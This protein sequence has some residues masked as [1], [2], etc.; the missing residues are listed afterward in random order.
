M[1][2]ATPRAPLDAQVTDPATEG[3][4]ADGAHRDYHGIPPVKPAPFE[5]TYIPTYFWLGGIAAGAWLAATAE[6]LAGEDDRDVVRAG[7]YLTLASVAGGTGLLIADL[8]RPERFLNMLRVFRARSAMSLGAWGLST[9]GAYSGMAA[10]LQ[11]AEDGLLGERPALA[12][13]SRGQLGRL[14]HLAG[15]PAALF[16]GSYTGVLLSSTSTPSWAA[17]TGVLSPLFAASAVSSGLAAVTAALY[18]ADDPAPRTVRRLARAHAVAAAA[19]TGLH[20]ADRRVAARLPSHAQASKPRRLAELAM[21]AAGMLAPVALAGLEAWA[22]GR[23]DRMEREPGSGEPAARARGFGLA[24][25]GLTLAGS[26][27]LRFLTVNEGERSARTPADTWTYAGGGED[28]AGGAPPRAGRGGA[29]S[30]R[31]APWGAA[32][33]RGADARKEG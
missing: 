28:G 16:V 12:R 7:R 33:H 20:L 22:A 2:Q 6:D 32:V 15:L 26:L 1:K 31:R 13:L 24:A 8:G 4:L 14:V 19:E 9:F 10:A 27:A 11:G 18:L 17:R 30:S 21:L 3:P 23:A 29:P 25:A 5:A